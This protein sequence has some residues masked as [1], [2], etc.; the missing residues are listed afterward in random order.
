MY[1]SNLLEKFTMLK[2]CFLLMLSLN[3]FALTFNEAVEI[4]SSHSSVESRIGMSNST[5][6]VG[7]SKGSWGDPMFKV[8]AK[9][10]PKD[11]LKRD[12][13][14]MTGVEFGISQ[15]ISLTNKYGVIEDSF[16]ELSKS[17]EFEAG[18]LKRRLTRSLWEILIL[19]RK[20]NEEREILKENLLWLEKILK[21]SKKLYVN[22]KTSQQAI[23]EIQIRKSEV[24]IQLNSREFELLKIKNALKYLLGEKFSR[25]KEGTIPWHILNKENKGNKDFKE[26]SLK[27]KVQAK[28]LALSAAN[29][30]YI[31]D[32]TFSLGYTKRS[33]IDGR[34]D[35]VGASVS[36]P[37]PFSG[38]KYSKKGSAVFEK[39]TA[40][41]E[42]ENYEKKK[43]RDSEILK[44]E[45]SK[46]EKDLFILNSKMIKFAKNS[47]AITS[48]SYGLGNSSYLELLQSELKLQNILILKSDLLS[49]RDSFKVAL[50]YTLGEK[51][52]E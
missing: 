17:Y 4:L 30:D 47:R 24:E 20:T 8:A 3:S 7:A 9:N 43:N 38:D 50:K 40:K 48:K 22:G 27:S 42:F 6:E 14:P 36:F 10:F 52:S 19:K 34:G 33:N 44:Y 5:K 11:S 2:I 1:L 21:V 45:I 26:L 35:F 16:R 23:L 32:I 15:K 46:A 13:T 25:I 41:K 37:L 18:D 12:E 31:P 51:L 28:D 49:K 29:K 39:Y